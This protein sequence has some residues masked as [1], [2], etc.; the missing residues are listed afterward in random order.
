VD[1]TFNTTLGNWT[2]VYFNYLN[3]EITRSFMPLCNLSEDASSI[4]L[5]TDTCNMV[6]HRLEMQLTANLTKNTLYKI[7][8]DD[9][10]NPDYGYVDIVPLTLVFATSDKKEVRASSSNIIFNYKPTQFIK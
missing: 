5:I 3:D 1:I 9:I 6:G 7:T 2:G 10:P 8:M 4:N